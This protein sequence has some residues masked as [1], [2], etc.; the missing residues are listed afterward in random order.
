VCLLDVRQPHELASSGI[1]GSLHIFVADLPSRLAEI[2]RD[3]E[4][5]TICAS[6]RRAALAASLLDRAGIPV[7]AVIAGGVQDWSTA[8]H[9][10]HS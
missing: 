4:V 2:P 7:A 5:W 9:L 10:V 3:R 6:G 8:S 1:P